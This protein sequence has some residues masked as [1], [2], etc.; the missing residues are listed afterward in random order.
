MCEFVR[1]RPSLECPRLQRHVADEVSKL[2]NLPAVGPE[3]TW[4]NK[5]KCVYMYAWKSIIL[6]YAGIGR[7][8]LFPFRPEEINSIFHPTFPAPDDDV[9]NKN[10]IYRAQ[11]VF[12]LVSGRSGSLRAEKIKFRFL[13]RTMRCYVSLLQS[14]Q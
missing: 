13:R 12:F 8:H 5:R 11:T 10:L 2:S 3:K 4:K 6:H 1:V 7:R 14:E 9:L